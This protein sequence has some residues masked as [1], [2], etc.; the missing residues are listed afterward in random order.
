MVASVSRAGGE[1]GDVDG[2]ALGEDV[3]EILEAL[4]A[5]PPGA[6]AGGERGGHSRA[7]A[8][9]EQ[10]AAVDASPA[11]PLELLMNCFDGTG[12]AHGFSSQT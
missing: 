1:L 5:R 7:G 9:R 10:R 3:G 2:K 11:L 4:L 8:A 6:S 12:E